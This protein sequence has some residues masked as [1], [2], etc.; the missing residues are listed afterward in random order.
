FRCRAVL[1]EQCDADTGGHLRHL[2]I[3]IEDGCAHLLDLPGDR[4]CG[5]QVGRTPGQDGEL[6]T[7]E[8]GD[9]VGSPQSVN[10]IPADLLE[11]QVATR[12][13]QRVVDMLETVE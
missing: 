3:E 12:V 5:S 6:V 13:P 10:Q 11:Q 7:A 2:A 9:R 8:S 4:R 1:R